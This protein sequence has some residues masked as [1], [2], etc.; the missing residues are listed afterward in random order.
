[1]T[2]REFPPQVADGLE[3]FQLILND[4]MEAEEMHNANNY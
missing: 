4:A 3:L 2:D 1:M